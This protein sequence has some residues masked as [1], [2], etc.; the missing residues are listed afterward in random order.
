MHFKIIYLSIKIWVLHYLIYYWSFSL[1]FSLL[2][3]WYNDSNFKVEHFFYILLSP[4]FAIFGL[5]DGLVII[6]PITV[7]YFF[8]MKY[9]YWHSYLMT[10]SLCYIVINFYM[11]FFVDGSYY[12]RSNHK[13]TN[14]EFN[15]FLIAIPCALI[16]ILVN[17]IVFR[18]LYHKLQK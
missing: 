18:K 9:N 2:S 11:L 10:I 5:L 7:F 13:E 15:N 12:V 17:W 6:I 8:N 16:S 14:F 3:I 1:I 4:I